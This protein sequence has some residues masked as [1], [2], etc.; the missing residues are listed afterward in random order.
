MKNGGSLAQIVDFR[1]SNHQANG[2]QPSGRGAKIV[3][4][5]LPTSVLH[6]CALSDKLGNERRFLALLKQQVRFASTAMNQAVGSS[7]LSG[8]AIL[9]NKLFVISN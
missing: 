2:T 5:I 8:R 3:S 1:A 7:N 4:D 6:S 9:N